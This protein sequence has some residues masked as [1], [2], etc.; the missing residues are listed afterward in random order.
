MVLGAVLA[1]A[2]AAHTV[3]TAERPVITLCLT[4]QFLMAVHVL[5]NM[6]CVNAQTDAGS[7]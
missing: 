5:L 2:A 6:G 1:T 7:I 3:C 4:T